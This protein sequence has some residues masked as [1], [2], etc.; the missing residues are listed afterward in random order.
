VTRFRPA[1]L[2]AFITQIID[3]LV[4]PDAVC[5]ERFKLAQ[6]CS[7]LRQKNLPKVQDCLSRRKD[8]VL[9]VIGQVEGDSIGVA[10]VKLLNSF[11]V[12]R[13]KSREASPTFTPPRHLLP[14]SKSEPVP[15]R[16]NSKF[17]SDA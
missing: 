15:G 8:E 5:T 14:A 13:G 10:L 12:E 16:R 2:E 4:S 6:I 9:A 1:D 17:A 3:A 7:M 11:Y